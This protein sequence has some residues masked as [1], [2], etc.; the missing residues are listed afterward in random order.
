MHAASKA[1]PVILLLLWGIT[2]LS[3][4]QRPAAE[5][6]PALHFTGKGTTVQAGDRLEVRW[7]DAV[8]PLRLAGIRCPPPG[9]PQGHTARFFTSEL[10]LGKEVRVIVTS[11]ESGRLLTWVI[12]PDGR[13]LN[14]EL[15]RAGLAWREPSTG[16]HPE[17]ARAEAEAR[18]AGDGLWGEPGFK[19]PASPSPEPPPPPS[20]RRSAAPR[21]TEGCIPRTQCCRVCSKGKAC[22]NSCISRSF[23][24]HKGHGCACDSWEICR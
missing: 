16:D 7:G 22:G 8:R 17:L 24:C 13:L 21:Q 19:P 18:A 9:Q 10:T 14:A 1:P 2:S 6:V 5:R 20:P 11:R 3:A 15:L 4:V 23:T 12:L